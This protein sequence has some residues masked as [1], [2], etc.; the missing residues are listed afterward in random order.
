MLGDS[1][2]SVSNKNIRAFINICHGQQHFLNGNN[3]TTCATNTLNFK[4]YSGTISE[5]IGPKF[6]RPSTKISRMRCRWRPSVSS[7]KNLGLIVN[8]FCFQEPRIEPATFSF[9]SFV[10]SLL[11]FKIARLVQIVFLRGQR[12]GPAFESRG[13]F[14]PRKYHSSSI[15]GNRKDVLLLF[16][17]DGTLTKS[18]QVIKPAVEQ[19]LEEVRPLASLGLVSGSDLDKI[20]W[21]MGGREKLAKFDFWFPENGLVAYKSGKHLASQNILLHLGEEKVQ[22]MINFSL[23]Y[24]SQLKLPFKRG[25]FV[26]FRTGIINLCPVGRSCSQVAVISINSFS[27]ASLFSNLSSNFFQLIALNLKPL[28]C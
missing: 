7:F 2:I 3:N 11:G 10:S 26:D 21:Q 19:V 4:I 14:S 13:T 6:A 12:L 27:L 18:R 15:A 1:V 16:D 28:A 9:Q 23:W 25:H 8:I 20:S 5:F 22:K 17:V 24:M